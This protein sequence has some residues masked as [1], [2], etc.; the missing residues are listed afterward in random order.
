MDLAVPIF[1]N[2]MTSGWITNNLNWQLKV[3]NVDTGLYKVI[4]KSDK[5]SL[6]EHKVSDI[7]LKVHFHLY[8]GPKLV[9]R[10][11]VAPCNNMG[12]VI[13][14]T[15]DVFPLI[16]LG[17]QFQLDFCLVEPEEAGFGL[18]FIPFL[19]HLGEE[20]SGVSD[21]PDFD[22]IRLSISDTFNNTHLVK[23]KKKFNTW[24]TAV[25][26]GSWEKLD[27]KYIWPVYNSDHTVPEE[28]GMSSQCINTVPFKH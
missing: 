5:A 20:G 13:G 21:I 24:S 18:G 28:Q 23:M 17:E 7:N 14:N 11:G 3:K 12:A 2:I 19:I 22:V 8:K 4:P 26:Q 15:Q 9:G 6:T 10:I 16:Q 25:T 1:I 27:P